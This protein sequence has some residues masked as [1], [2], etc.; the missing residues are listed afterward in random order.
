MKRCVGLGLAAA[1]LTSVSAMAGTTVVFDNFNNNGFFTPFNASTSPNIRYGDGGWLGNTQPS[2]TLTR[3]VLGLV[4]SNGSGA[5]STDIT[6][7]FNDGDP[8]GQV[9]GSGAALWSTT[10]PNVQ[11]P[12][13]AGP[14]FFSLEI[15][16][17]EI[18]TLGGFNNIGW[19]VGVSNFDYDGEF[20]FQASAANGQNLGFYTNNASFYNGSSW[21][22]FSFGSNP[23][24]GVANFVATIYTPEPTS[25][26]LLSL[27]AL[28]AGRRR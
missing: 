14:Q 16:L 11:L 18:V 15:D 3:M 10:I 23:N 17:P 25:A 12:G 22:L 8:S 20:G 13:G 24:T 2:F 19:S 28:A 21:S 26:A 1:A 27:L 9:F 4:A 6:F 7:T 5:G